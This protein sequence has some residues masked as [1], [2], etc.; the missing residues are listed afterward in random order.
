M[1]C[2]E[3]THVDDEQDLGVA[4]QSNARDT[5]TSTPSNVRLSRRTLPSH[6]L[7]PGS[8]SVVRAVGD[9]QPSGHVPGQVPAPAKVILFIPANALWP[10]FIS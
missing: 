7:G 6:P 1:S 2:P 5:E 8:L 4:V 10:A 3:D 9:G